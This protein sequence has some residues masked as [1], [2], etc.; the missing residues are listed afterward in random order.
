MRRGLVRAVRVVAPFVGA[1]GATDTAQAQGTGAER[2]NPSCVAPTYYGQPETVTYMTVRRV[3]Q[4]S[5]GVKPAI[6]AIVEAVSFEPNA[7]SP[8]RIRVTGTF[9]VPR[10]ISDGE[11]M[12]PRRGELHFSLAPGREEATRREWVELAAFAGSG[13]V[14]GFGHY[15]TNRPDMSGRPVATALSV[16]IHQIGRASDT[17]VYPGPHERSVIE[18]FDGPDDLTPRFGEPSAV[19]VERLRAAARR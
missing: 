12:P 5:C 10:P 18:K 6:Y 2:A 8:E 7:A 3:G 11:H 9:T 16:V 1:L 14:I 4:V 19:L 17:Q 15:W 13:E